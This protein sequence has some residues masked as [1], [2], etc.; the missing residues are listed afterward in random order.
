MLRTEAIERARNKPKKKKHLLL[1]IIDILC[2]VFIHTEIAI[3]TIQIANGSI[4]IAIFLCYAQC[5][6]MGRRGVK[7]FFLPIKTDSLS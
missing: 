3:L 7:P 2:T 6:R 5:A 1:P 4:Q